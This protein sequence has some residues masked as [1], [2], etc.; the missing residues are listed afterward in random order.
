MIPLLLERI[1]FTTP[2]TIPLRERTE[3]F[4]W[5]VQNHEVLERK[6]QDTSLYFVA[7]TRLREPVSSILVNKFEREEGKWK[8]FEKFKE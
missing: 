4:Q 8:I 6:R 1:P 2:P 3:A 7:S 5:I